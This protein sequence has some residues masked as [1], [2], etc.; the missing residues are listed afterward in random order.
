MFDIDIIRN[1]PERVKKDL[2]KRKELGKLEWVDKTRELD[3]EWREKKK[4]LD[5]LRHQRNVVSNNIRA[6]KKQ[7]KDASDLIKEAGELPGKIEKLEEE[8]EQL[9]EKRNNFLMRLPNLM[10][11]SVPFGEDDSQNV[12]IR[13]VG[14][15]PEFDFEPRNHLEIA[16]NLG[17]IDTERGAKVAGAGFLYLKDDLAMLDL[18]LQRYAVDF[19]RKKGFTLIIPPYMLKREAYEGVV[20]LADFENV[21]YK[22]KDQDLYMIATSEHPIGSRFKDESFVKDELP[23]KFVG[24][25]PCFRREVGTHGKY[26]KGLFRMHQFHKVEQFVFSMPEDSWE[27]HEEL[28]K[29]TEEMFQE[30]GLHYRVVNI[31]TGDLGSIAAKKYDIEVWMADDNFREE[32]SNSNCTDYQARRLNIKYRE[33][34]GQAPKDYVHTLNNTAIAT[35]RT[36]IAILEQFQQKDGSVIIPEV[37]RPYMGKDRLKRA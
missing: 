18:A 23:K 37:L 27:I 20:D 17:L 22:I 29:N 25:S 30:L 14:K 3:Q 36:M 1:N 11:E 28:Q 26:T 6:L 31:C 21:M 7:G 34:Q 4:K 16:E 33:K 24:I 10:H 13:V 5:E 9:H 35:S 32:G 12:E 2:E 15:K 19:L 8:V